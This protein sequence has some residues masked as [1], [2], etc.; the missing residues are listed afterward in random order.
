MT[1]IQ[2]KREYDLQEGYATLTNRSDGRWGSFQNTYAVW[3][4]NQSTVESITIR[5]KIQLQAGYYYVTGTVDNSGSVTIN[6]TYTIGLYNFNSAINRTDKGTSTRV[7]HG[8]GSMDVVINASNAGDVAGV[9]VTISS[10]LSSS[11][12]SLVWSTRLV[13]TESISRY[14]VTMPFRANVTAHVWG[15][16][17]GGGGVDAGTQGGVGSPGLYNTGTFTVLEGDILEVCV[18]EGGR[19]GSSSSGSAPG[20]RAGQGRL[21]INGETQKSLNGGAGTAA[22][23]G[24]SSGGGGGGGAASAVLVNEVPVVVAGG[25]G[26]GGGA[27]NDGNGSSQ[28]SRRNATITNNAIGAAG[29]DLRGENGQSK[30][31]D[32]GGSGG[33]G[34][35]YPGGQGG[36]AYPGDAS[37]Y[38]GQCGGNF[39]V[40]TASTGSNSIFYK[41]GYSAGGSTGGGTGQNGRVVLLIDPLSLCSLKV[42]GSW[43]QVGESFVKVNGTWKDVATVY[44]KVGDSW[45]PMGGVGQGDVELVANAQ[46]YGTSARSY[47]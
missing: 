10:E 11:V 19:G 4:S 13:G 20:G 5:R 46:L 39:P 23:P 41:S 3:T 15:A 17:G 31:G 32:G 14:L 44:V 28:S 34:G 35:G 27:G 37:G 43:R 18:G 25:G 12:G 9:A 2:I 38:A 26:G 40:N 21:S 45:K 7:Y 30:G 8:G 36:A 33:G 47:S 1:T 24:G 42:S 29:S 6:G 16:G 22:G